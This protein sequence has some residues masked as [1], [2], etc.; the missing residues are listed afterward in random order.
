M[1]FVMDGIDADYGMEN[2]YTHN[3]SLDCFQKLFIRDQEQ[4]YQSNTGHCFDN[5]II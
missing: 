2:E 1:E 3:E 5:T 4:T